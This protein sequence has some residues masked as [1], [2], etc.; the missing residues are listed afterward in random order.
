MLPLIAWLKSYTIFGMEAGEIEFFWFVESS[1][2]LQ[3]VDVL[4]PNEELPCP[5]RCLV[6][7]ALFGKD[8]LFSGPLPR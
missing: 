8:P 4:H 3:M 2:V 6:T 5:L 7:G 1:G